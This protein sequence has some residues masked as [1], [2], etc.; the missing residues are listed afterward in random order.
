MSGKSK[1]DPAWPAAAVEMKK[2]SEIKERKNN[3]N[4]HD[5]EQIEQ[6]VK[7]LRTF[8]W[9][10]PMLVDEEGVLVAG[11]GRRRAALLLGYDMGPVIVARGWSEDMKRAYCVADN[12]LARNSEWDQKLLRAELKGLIAIDFDMEL[13][14]FTADE[15]NELIIDPATLESNDGKAEEVTM[16]KCPTCGRYSQKR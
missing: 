3:P 13:V 11:H 6:L 4:T 5:L 8:G 1:G 15:L 14:G 16:K 7:S 9:T 12:K 10:M 2:L